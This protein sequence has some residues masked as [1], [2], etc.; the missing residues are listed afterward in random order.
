M[1]KLQ[2]DVDVLRIGSQMTFM[3]RVSGLEGL[4]ANQ[5]Q[6]IKQQLAREL[7]AVD[8]VSNTYVTKVC[9][10]TKVPNFRGIRLHGSCISSSGASIIHIS[11][12]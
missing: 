4:N 10:F 7:S 2:E 11:L 3:Q 1:K 9:H 12:I 5:L 6:Q 8:S